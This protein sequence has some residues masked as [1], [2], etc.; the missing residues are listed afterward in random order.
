MA[1]HRPVRL[2]ETLAAIYH[3]S[4]VE[5]K[6]VHTP[7]SLMPILGKIFEEEEIKEIL[8]KVNNQVFLISVFNLV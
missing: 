2:A 8:A 4:F 3:A 7:E 1:V 6:D 5:H